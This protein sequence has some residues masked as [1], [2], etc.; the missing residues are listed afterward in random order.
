M[1]KEKKLRLWCHCML[2]ILWWCTMFFFFQCKKCTVAQ[3]KVEKQTKCKTNTM[4]E[5]RRITHRW[6]LRWASRSVLH[7]LDRLSP[8][9]CSSL[10]RW[11]RRRW[12]RPRP[13]CAGPWW[14]SRWWIP[15][16]R[17]RWWAG[18]Q[19]ETYSGSWR[20]DRGSHRRPLRSQGRRQELQ[21]GEKEWSH[22]LE[23]NT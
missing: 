17:C 11:H 23:Q 4:K 1:N 10:S 6:R 8:H 2:T 9:T 20:A 12:R 13:R 14:S 3:N 7:S 22:W 18:C 15:S 21:R 16:S 5:P 19:R